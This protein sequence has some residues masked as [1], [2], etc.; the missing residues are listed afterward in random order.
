MLMVQYSPVGSKINNIYKD[1]HLLYS[2]K[3][4]FVL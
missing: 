1:V 3:W 2:I 4:T